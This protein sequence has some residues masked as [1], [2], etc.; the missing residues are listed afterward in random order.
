MKVDVSR[1]LEGL[2]LRMKEARTQRDRAITSARRC[3][4]AL[5]REP[6]DE[7][8][9][10]RTDTEA[11]NY[12]EVVVRHQTELIVCEQVLSEI[13]RQLAEEMQQ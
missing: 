6:L 2:A 9:I 3:Y 10:H 8:H 13:Q 7:Y 11:L 5:E 1:L 12:A 4:E